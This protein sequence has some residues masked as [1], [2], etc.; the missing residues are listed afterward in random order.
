MESDEPD[1]NKPEEMQQHWEAA[2]L[3]AMR[4]MEATL[5][6]LMAQA[7]RPAAV[8]LAMM[9][10]LN[11]LQKGEI[12]GPVEPRWRAEAIT[13]AAQRT[14]LRIVELAEATTRR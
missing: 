7:P 5:A 6:A 1:V 10:C 2:Q 9:Q 4:M 14:S 12:T 11:R 13:S 3:G 8:K